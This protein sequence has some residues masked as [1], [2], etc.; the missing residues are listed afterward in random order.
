[1]IILS[2]KKT[3]SCFHVVSGIYIRQY[4]NTSMR[5][6]TKMAKIGT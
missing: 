3:K 4:I 6:L 1:M 2:F 5:A